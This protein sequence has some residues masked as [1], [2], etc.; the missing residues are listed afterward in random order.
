DEERALRARIDVVLEGR[1]AE[2]LAGLSELIRL[3]VEL[4]ALPAQRALL[5]AL[6]AGLPAHIITFG[7]AAALLLLHAITATSVPR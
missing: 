3:A 4:R 6:R 2:R 7:V 1:G 5:A